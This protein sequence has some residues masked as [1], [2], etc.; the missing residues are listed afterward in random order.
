MQNEF[1]CVQ[2]NDCRPYFFKDKD[3]AFE[4]LWQC[5]VNANAAHF[6]KEELQDARFE[7]FNWYAIE[8]FGEV[9]VCGFED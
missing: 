9:F 5:F 4:F 1:Y 8:D 2:M 6:T 7:L 3:K